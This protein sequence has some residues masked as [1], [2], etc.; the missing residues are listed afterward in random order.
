MIQE[1]FSRVQFSGYH[2]EVFRASR[3]LTDSGVMG[4]P[5]NETR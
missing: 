2:L 1:A 5:L 4:D 3:E